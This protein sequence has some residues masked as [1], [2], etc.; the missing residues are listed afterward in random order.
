MLVFEGPLH[1]ASAQE[2]ITVSGHVVVRGASG[3]SGA[4]KLRVVVG[5]VD[6]LLVGVPGGEVL[7]DM[8]LAH[9]SERPIVIAACAPGAV[10]AVHRAAA[11]GADLVTVRPHDA[12]RLAPILFA[13]SRLV[14]QRHRLASASGMGAALDNALDE[15]SEREP[16]ALQ[17]F[18]QFQDA[19][20]REIERARRYGYPLAIAMFRVEVALPAPPPGVLGI[21]RARAGNALV[22][23]IRDI[24]VVTE[25]EQDRF[26]VLL[27]HT[28]R[29]AGAEVARRILGAVATVD[30]VIAG[31]RSFSPKLVGAV[32]G[33]RSGEPLSF[34]T[35]LDD[36]TQL[37]D[38]ALVTGAALAVEP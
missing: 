13:A 24:D 34:S 18:E 10:E 30:P 38:Q 20:L 9:G 5:Q 15:L 4:E 31:G 21:L 29:L 7:I 27:P 3:P 16:G 35:L 12:E 33:A 1:L 36:A 22:N 37:L 28:D 11:A 26:L 17:S 23:A 25:L 19:A 32:A 8:A 2:A 6:A 14:E